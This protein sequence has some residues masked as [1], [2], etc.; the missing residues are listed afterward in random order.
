[1]TEISPVKGVKFAF[2]NRIEDELDPK[3][4]V[5]H[6]LNISG[7][8]YNAPRKTVNRFLQ[9]LRFSDTD[10]SQRIGTLS[11]GQKARAALAKC[12]LSGAG[13]MIVVSH[14]RF[15]IDSVAWRSRPARW[16]WPV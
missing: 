2:F 15:F 6:A 16:V 9:L 1:M 13:A 14:D 3:D 4:S 8:A 12:L 11:G 5:S 7:L 10:L